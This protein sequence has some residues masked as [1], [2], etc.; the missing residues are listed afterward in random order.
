MFLTL[1]R[2]KKVLL[3]ESSRAISVLLK[4]IYYIHLIVCDIFFQHSVRRS[5]CSRKIA[6]STCPLSERCCGRSTSLH[7]K[8]PSIAKRR[9]L[10]V[11]NSVSLSVSV[12]VSVSVSIFVFVS[13]Y[14]AHTHT[15]THTHTR[16]HTHTHKISFNVSYSHSL[17]FLSLCLFHVSLC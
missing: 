15:H 6:S 4:N 17:F 10:L 14:L 13:V 1:F 8:K 12:R 16:T 9:V 3:G 11:L 2:I 5:I 7:P